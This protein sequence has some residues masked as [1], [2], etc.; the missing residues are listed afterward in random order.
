[1]ISYYLLVHHPT[2]ETLDMLDLIHKAN[3]SNL[4]ISS[5]FESIPMKGLFFN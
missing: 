3:G 1:M 5:N 4:I 2:L